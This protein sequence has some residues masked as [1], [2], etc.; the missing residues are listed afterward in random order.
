MN[1]QD[2]IELAEKEPATVE[3]T[4]KALQS[5]IDFQKTRGA[6]LRAATASDR[7]PIQ[8]SKD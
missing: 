6:L 4:T 3:T 5:V 8:H 2:L 7:S 1:D